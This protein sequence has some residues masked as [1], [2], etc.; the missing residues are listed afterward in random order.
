MLEKIGIGCGMLVVTT[1]VHAAAMDLA[2]QALKRVHVERWAAKTRVTRVTV[3]G[4]LA[5]VMFLASMVEAG[6]WGATYL[7]VGAFA[8]V[9]KAMYFSAVTYTTLGFGDVTLGAEWRTLSAIEAANGILMFGWTTALLASTVQ[10]VYFS[11][12]TQQPEG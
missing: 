10:K 11:P 12:E 5:L 1:I 8:E 4:A 9:E 3:V 7:A 2:V 6:L